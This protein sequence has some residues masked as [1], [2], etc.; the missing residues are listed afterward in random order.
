MGSSF[1]HTWGN[2]DRMACSGS[3]GFVGDFDSGLE[4]SRAST[5]QQRGV[6]EARVVEGFAGSGDGCLALGIGEM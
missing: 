4:R 3:G 6:L 5:N 1:V 2:D